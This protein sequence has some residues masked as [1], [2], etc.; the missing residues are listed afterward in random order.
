M[1]VYYPSLP[2]F[3]RLAS[4]G[5]VVPICRQL[6]ADC[7]TPVSAF[8]KMAGE[9][10]AF[11]LES[12]TGGEKIGRYST[13]GCRPF[14]IF[15][16]K[17]N[18]VEIIRD[19]ETRKFHA[20]DPLDA[21]GQMLAQFKPV[22][23]EEFPG[24][25]GGLTG[26]AIGYASYDA[27]RYVEHL[28]DAP[29]DDR[30]LPDLYFLFCDSTIVFDN[31]N[32]T[33]KVVSNAHLDGVTTAQAYHEAVERIESIVELLRRPVGVPTED[34]TVTSTGERE[35]DSNFEKAD[36]L[37][38]V[39]ACK[40]YIRAGDILQVVPSQRLHTQT[41]ADPFNI[42]RSLRVINPSPYM[43]YLKLDDLCLIGSSPEVMVQVE[44]GTITLRPIA[45]TRPRGDTEEEDKALEEELLADP[46]ERAEH[47]MLVDLGRNDVGRV[48]EYNTVEI[49]ECMV[50]ERY[51]HVM[52]IVSNVVGRLR[53]GCTA[54]DALRASL[55][56]GTL[57]GA[58]KVRAMQI[59][60]E[61]ESTRRGPYGGA[62]GYIDFFGNLNTCITIR[63]IVMKGRD[64]W[65]QAGGGI[66]AD[67]VPENE[68]E[69]TLSK[70]RG[71]LNAIDVAERQLHNVE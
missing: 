37:M 68:W 40:D 23:P 9:P 53:P 42:Y 7:L 60:D 2:T 15:K 54:L 39:D 43:F 57:S 31:V 11:I 45:G 52:H 51:S 55:P 3:E 27:V 35:F 50:I 6:M 13:L 65:V 62:V 36:Y 32:K 38:M 17:D 49:T 56:A 19:G 18:N 63:T 8:R 24:G 10:Y 28:P 44:G 59:I 14:A 4:R 25:A 12:V 30:N 22:R 33:V 47:I 64:A 69:E 16:A 48:A 29:P 66:V 71:L 21:F 58:P 1:S 41:S 20:D 5:N 26:G 46:K 61:F 67:S 34:I 70:A